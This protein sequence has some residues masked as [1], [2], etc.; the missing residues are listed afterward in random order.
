MCTMYIHVYIYST[1]RFYQNC[2]VSI[3]CGFYEQR[4]NVDRFSVKI[5]FARPPSNESLAALFVKYSIV[6]KYQQIFS[7]HFF[8]FF[9][10][11]F[12]KIRGQDFCGDN[13]FDRA[14]SNDSLV[15]L[16]L[17]YSIPLSA[18]HHS[19]SLSSLLIDSL[20]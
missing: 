16:L 8:A 9:S 15:A 4:R 13:S 6:R 19:V 7:T 20:L 1:H 10:L 14:P 2:Q 12:L 18:C 5:S 11:G 3:I 17:K